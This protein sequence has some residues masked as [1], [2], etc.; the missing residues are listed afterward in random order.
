MVL[1]RATSLFLIMVTIII[2]CS[3]ACFAANDINVDIKLSL[4]MEPVACD[5]NK[6]ECQNLVTKLLSCLTQLMIV[7]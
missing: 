5:N 3:F 6:V 4:K 2:A 7:V 1:P